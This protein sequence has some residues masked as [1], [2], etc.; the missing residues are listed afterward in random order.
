M[1]KASFKGKKVK[2]KITI[3]IAFTMIITFLLVSYISSKISDAIILVSDK[4]VETENDLTFKEAFAKKSDSGVDTDKLIEIIRNKN[5]EIVEVDF[6]VIECEKMLLTVIGEI[7][8]E[9]AKLT[10]D[11]YLLNIPL[12]YITKSPILVN[13]GPKIPVK[14]VTTDVVLGDVQTKITEFGI[15]SAMLELYLNFEI[16]YNA[17]LPLEKQTKVLKY[18]ALV[19]SKVI[20]GKVPD[21]YNGTFN[22]KS[23]T[24][25]LPIN[26]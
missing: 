12:G 23:D 4:M 15:N 11:G 14:I 20:N 10:S 3:I 19:A 16:K 1:K 7:N 2:N 17:T 6:K 21:F 24:F 9:A 22:K 5:D 13:L 25:N 26:E 8:K 18:R